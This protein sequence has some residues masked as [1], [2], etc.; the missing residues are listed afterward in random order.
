[1]KARYQYRIYHTDQQRLGLAKLFGCCRVVFN[2]ALARKAF[3]STQ[4]AASGEDS[5]ILRY[6]L[7]RYLSLGL[8]ISSIASLVSRVTFPVIAPESP[9]T[10]DGLNRPDG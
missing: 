7:I 1:M 9:D 8:E 6:S 3:I 10:N 2:D 5:S 4:A